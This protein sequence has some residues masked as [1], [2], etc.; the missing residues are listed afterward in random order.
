MVGISQQAANYAASEKGRAEAKKDM[1]TFE[2]IV[3]E[4]K[5]YNFE[6]SLSLNGKSSAFSGLNMGRQITDQIP[7]LGNILRFLKQVIYMQ[8]RQKVSKRK[9]KKIFSRT[10]DKTHRKNVQPVPMRGGFRI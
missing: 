1:A 10:A 3:S 4:N 6:H 9:S 5:V 7:I 2:K 8:K